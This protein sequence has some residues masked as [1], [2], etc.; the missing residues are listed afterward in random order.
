MDGYQMTM[1]AVLFTA[2]AVVGYFGW[3]YWRTSEPRR[4]GGQARRERR[5]GLIEATSIGADRKLLLVRRDGAEHLILIGGPID[6][7]VESGIETR[8]ARPVRAGEPALRTPEL[9]AERVNAD[10]GQPIAPKPA[11][12]PPTLSTRPTDTD[13]SLDELFAEMDRPPATRQR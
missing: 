2:V 7:V 1:L 6:L 9:A 4:G 8:G 10:L 5:L 12:R 11:V 13:T 3:R